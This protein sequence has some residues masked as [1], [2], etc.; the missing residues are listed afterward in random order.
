[1]RKFTCYC[2][3]EKTSNFGVNK[4]RANKATKFCK[5]CNTK[6]TPTERKAR[7]FKNILSILTKSDIEL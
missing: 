3:L 5:D 1:M 2:C 7:E 6:Y 4:R